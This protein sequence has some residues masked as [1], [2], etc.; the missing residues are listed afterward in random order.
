[1]EEINY[2]LGAGAA[3]NFLESYLATKVE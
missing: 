3:Q 1:M 2:H